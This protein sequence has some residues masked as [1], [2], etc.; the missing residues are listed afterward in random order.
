MIKQVKYQTTITL[1]FSEKNANLVPR[2]SHL[3]TLGTRLK[4]RASKREN[5]LP[6]GNVTRAWCAASVRYAPAAHPAHV[7]FH[8]ASDFYTRLWFSE[9]TGRV[10]T[11]WCSG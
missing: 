1:S 9:P 10:G 2:V 6:R 4:E 3:E 8:T 11:R 5:R 7:M